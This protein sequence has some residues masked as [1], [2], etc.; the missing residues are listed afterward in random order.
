MQ[1]GI[2]P[3]AR[4]SRSPNTMA[5][6]LMTAFQSYVDHN[7]CAS[8][9]RCASHNSLTASR[10]CHAFTGNI[11]AQN[12]QSC[13]KSGL[14]AKIL[15]VVPANIFWRYHRVAARW[16]TQLPI[17]ERVIFT[18]IIEFVFKAS[19]DQYAIFRR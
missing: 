8:T 9:L 1:G 14:A 7:L 2:Q 6:W 11:S 17:R 18:T 10:C 19:A 13:E 5:N 3:V 4:V 12:Q 16:W 15:F